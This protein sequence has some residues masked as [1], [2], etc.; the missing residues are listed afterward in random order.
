LSYRIEVWEDRAN[1]YDRLINSSTYSY[2]IAYDNWDTVF[3][4]DALS[5]GKT[6][7]GRFKNLADLLHQVCTQ[8]AFR[9]CPISSLSRDGSYYVTISAAIQ[10]LSAE[11]V[12]EV[13]NWLGG[14]QSDDDPSKA[15]GLLGFVVDMFTSK[16]KRAD[17]K[18][19][20]FAL[21]ALSRG[22]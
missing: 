20:I 14:G 8:H 18:S 22:P 17:A 12:K 10:A 15:G 21:E 13:E 7:T 6:E 19:S 3:C 11:R 16:A 2:K 5:R 9:A 4:V 1:W